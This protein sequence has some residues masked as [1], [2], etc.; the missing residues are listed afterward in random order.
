MQDQRPVL[1][2][3]CRSPIL[4]TSGLCNLVAARLGYG[5]DWETCFTDLVRV[6]DAAAPLILI[7]GINESPAAPEIMREALRE[8]LIQAERV[9]IKVCIT[10]RTDF[11]QFYRSPFWTA[12][13]PREERGASPRGEDL[14]LFPI[15]SF[16]E[17]VE[18][19]FTQFLVRGR[20]VG[21]AEERCRNPLILRLFC[22]A[23]RGRDVGTIRELRL[24]LLFK[25]F[26]Q[27]KTEQVA[28]IKG[29][30]QPDA[31]ANLVLKVAALM[32][33]RRSTV[34]PR[35]E[36]AATLKLAPVDLDR[37]ESLYNRTLDEEI[38]LEENVDEEAGIRNVV[39][40]CRPLRRVCDLTEHLHRG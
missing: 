8:L 32:R 22:E 33:Q 5:S 24:Y 38:I 14:P 30:K 2:V 31:V 20:L 25:L 1:F 28:E 12:Y 7:D 9:G 40:G 16:P 17:I 3:T 10:C 4:E 21:D 36:V 15:E 23:Y 18:K 37:S 39:F 27:R 34:V 13:L 26:W 6:T 19:Y 11:W 29:L 35:S